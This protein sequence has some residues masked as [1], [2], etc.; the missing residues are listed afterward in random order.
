MSRILIKTMR[1]QVSAI[2]Q[3]NNVDLVS[4]VHDHLIVVNRKN[5]CVH[6]GGVIEGVEHDAGNVVIV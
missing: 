2:A 6:I 3:S 4:H 1:N 5:G